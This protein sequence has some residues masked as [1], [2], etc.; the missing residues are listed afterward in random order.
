MTKVLACL[1]GSIYAQSVCDHA[2]W[3]ASRLDAQLDLLQVIGRR[4]V[5][6]QDRSGRILPSARRQLLSE[7][8]QL[9]EQRSKLLMQ[10]ARMQMDEA[11]SD[12]TGRGMEVLVTLRHG[13]LLET[14]TGLE[15]DADMIVIGKRGEAADFATLHLGSNLE[16]I[17]RSATRPVLIASRGIKPIS[18][19]IIAFDGRP[20]ALKAV[21]A[22]SQ[23]P[24][25]CGLEGIVVTSGDTGA[26]GSAALDKAV[27]R[28]IAQGMSVT[29]RMLDGPPGTAI[30][31]VMA[32][33]GA[34]LLVM[35]A[36]GRPRLQSMLLGSTTAEVI[37]GSRTPVLVYR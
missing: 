1:D 31:K 22:L 24:L 37:R 19:F 20:S 6:A 26:N 10:N 27:Q 32:D 12:L 7:L 36:Y 28:L 2:A 4:E 30:P 8:A 14:L 35:G 15:A 23:S 13:D 5:A 34:D 16:R 9:D 18:R 17:L 3:A 11:R 21:E 25:L 33:E 29:G